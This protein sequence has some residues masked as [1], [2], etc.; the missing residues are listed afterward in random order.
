VKRASQL[1]WYT[2]E[3]KNVG[4]IPGARN[5]NQLLISPDG[6]RV[7][8]ELNGTERTPNRTIRLLELSTGILSPFT[9]NTAISYAD[10]AWS[11]DSRE[12]IYASF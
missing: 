5:Y 1:H 12:L 7:V 11:P 10:S 3:G 8:V 2:R 4:S 6:K 9:P